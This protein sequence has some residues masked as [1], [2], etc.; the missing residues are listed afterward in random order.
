M[1]IIIE[2]AIE[3]SSTQI[4]SLETKLGEIFNSKLNLEFQVS[5][6]VIG[7]IRIVA[8]NKTLDLS[9]AAKLT[10]LKASLIKEV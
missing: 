8:P 5:E 1:K 10:L 6:D 9:L 7:G 4:A 3:L 2:S